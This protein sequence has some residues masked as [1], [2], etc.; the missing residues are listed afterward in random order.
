[1][2]AALNTATALPQEW[3]EWVMTNIMRGVQTD[4]IIDT[5]KNHQQFACRS[6]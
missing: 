3:Q 2:S 4:A 6:E 5:L 1:M